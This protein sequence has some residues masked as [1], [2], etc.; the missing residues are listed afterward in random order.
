MQT[1]EE[2]ARAIQDGKQEALIQL[3][4]QCYGFIRLQACKWAGAWAKRADFDA[5]DLTQAGY[6]ALF[7][8][9]KA[10]QADRGNFLSLL[11]FHLKTEFSKVAGCYTQAQLKQPLNNAISLDSPAYNDEGNETTIG[12]TIPCEEPGFEEVEEA[13]QKA[14]IAEVVREAVNSLPEKQCRAVDAHYL[15]GQTYGDIAS[16]FNVSPAYIAQLVNQGLHKLRKGRYAPTLSELLWGRRDFYRHTGYTAWKETG[17]SVQEWSVL[18]KEREIKRNNLKDTRG[19]KIRYCI[20]VLGMDR[21]QA[22]Q[23]FPV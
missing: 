15:Q 22:E 23:L 17:C 2:L 8:A 19:K 18:W 12:D 5:D 20:D 13:M 10:F 14:H 4:Y 6:I 16:L 3:W 21:G 11:A 1:N 7:E 9:V